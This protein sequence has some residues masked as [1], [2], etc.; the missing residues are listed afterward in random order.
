MLTYVGL[1]FEQIDLILLSPK[2]T[3]LPNCNVLLWIKMCSAILH[4][5]NNDDN[6]INRISKFKYEMGK[7]Y[8]I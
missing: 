2:I 1:P 6:Y 8:E 7:R 5:K 3:Q 4:F